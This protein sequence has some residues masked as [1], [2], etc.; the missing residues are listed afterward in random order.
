[1]AK[2]LFVRI[3]WMKYY[4]GSNQN[5][6]QPSGS[7]QYNEDN[8]GHEAYNFDPINKQ[9]YGCFEPPIWGK[10]TLGRISREAQNKE[11]DG[12]LIVYVAPKNGDRNT[13]LVVVGWYNN[14]TIYRTKQEI[15][16]REY[17]YFAKTNIENS[18]LLPTRNRI[19]KAKKGKEALANPLFV[20]H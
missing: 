17:G 13:D 19:W 5:D 6:P 1:M 3:G 15:E 4:R 18:V 2:S 8:E 10:I 12:V 11:I 20:I 14:A 9:I 7:G 16:G